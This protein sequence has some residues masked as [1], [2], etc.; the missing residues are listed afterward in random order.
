MIQ[1][2]VFLC[3]FTGD[4]CVNA[5]QKVEWSAMEKA[6][7]SSVAKKRLS[8]EFLPVYYYALRVCLLKVKEVL[9]LSYL[10]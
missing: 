10:M 5:A 1:M 4:W 2:S 7:H 9:A 3:V 8:D 6:K